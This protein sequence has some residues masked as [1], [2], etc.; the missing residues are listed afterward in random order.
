MVGIA[1]HELQC[2][3]PRR[4]IELRLGLPCPEMQMSSV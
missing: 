2:V 3:P 1:H 4:Q